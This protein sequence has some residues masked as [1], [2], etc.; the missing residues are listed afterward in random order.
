MAPSPQ[1]DRD[2]DRPE[3]K[4]RPKGFLVFRI[5]EDEVQMAY[6]TP[7]GWIETWSKPL[8]R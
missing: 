5:M 1:Y 4:S 2:L 3:T 7:E 8:R 6:R